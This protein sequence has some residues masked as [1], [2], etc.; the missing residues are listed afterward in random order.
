MLLRF[1]VKCKAAETCC[2]RYTGKR[3]KVRTRTVLGFGASVQQKDNG[4]RAHS[5]GFLPTP[6]HSTLQCANVRPF[7]FPC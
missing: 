6:S 3:K 4:V 2:A 7:G 5:G 1:Y